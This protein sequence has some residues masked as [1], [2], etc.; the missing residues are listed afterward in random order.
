MH[1]CGV[2]VTSPDG[3][4][5]NFPCHGWLGRPDSGDLQGESRHDAALTGGDD[6]CGENG[7][8]EHLELTGAR[9]AVRG[10]CQACSFN[11]CPSFRVVH[12]GAAAHPDPYVMRG[13]G[14]TADLHCLAQA[15]L[16]SITSC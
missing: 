2:Q 10:S 14:R 7:S 16:H 8:S 9:W 11:C 3:S 15:C 13:A 5:L 4:V 12:E 1:G 6:R